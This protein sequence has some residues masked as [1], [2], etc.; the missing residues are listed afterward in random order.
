MSGEQEMLINLVV[1]N[2]GSF[3]VVGVFVDQCFVL[4]MGNQVVG[5]E[6]WGFGKVCFLVGDIVFLNV[7]KEVIQ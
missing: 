3:I 6:N 7:E 1:K 5:V 4:C 2:S